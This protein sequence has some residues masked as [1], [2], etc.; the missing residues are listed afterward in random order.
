MGLKRYLKKKKII[1]K[2]KIKRKSFKISLPDPNTVLLILIV[3][4]LYEII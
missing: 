3:L 4:R 2:E 1:I